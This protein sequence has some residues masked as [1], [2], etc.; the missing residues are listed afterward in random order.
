MNLIFTCMTFNMLGFLCGLGFVVCK[1]AD[2]LT[3]SW[4]CCLKTLIWR[5]LSKRVWLGII[6]FWMNNFLY[7]Y[8]YII[9]IIGRLQTMFKNW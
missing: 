2:Q 6:Y 1:T 9:Y 7:F 5:G 3:E 8:F 4:L